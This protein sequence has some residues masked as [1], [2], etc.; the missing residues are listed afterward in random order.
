MNHVTRFVSRTNV[1][2]ITRHID[3]ADARRRRIR[4]NAPHALLA[5]L[6]LTMAVADGASGISST[7]E[8]HTTNALAAGA[9]VP[10]DVRVLVNDPDRLAEVVLR[11][12]LH[13]A[14]LAIIAAVD[15]AMFRCET[16]SLIFVCIATT[17]G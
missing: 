7:D 2:R 10:L 17:S 12:D 15:N 16:A 8:I 5:D 3:F 1:R 14:A 4:G 9:I 6:G 11:F 13:T